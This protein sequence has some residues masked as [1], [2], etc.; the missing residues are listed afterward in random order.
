MIQQTPHMIPAHSQ[1]IETPIPVHQAAI[2]R[3][4]RHQ[5]FLHLCPWSSQLHPVQHQGQFFLPHQR[6]CSQLSQDCCHI[7]GFQSAALCACPFCHSPYPPLSTFDPRHLRGK[8]A[9]LTLRISFPLRLSLL[10]PP[11]TSAASAYPQSAC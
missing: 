5:V 8:N 2:Q 10:S 9:Q 7:F 11:E 3:L 1:N 6:R 4:H